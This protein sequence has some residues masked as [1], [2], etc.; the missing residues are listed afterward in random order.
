MLTAM[1]P[2][3]RAGFVQEYF[4]FFLQQWLLAP[5]LNLVRPPPPPPK[6][7]RIHGMWVKPWILERDGKRAYNT[8]MAGLYSTDMPSFRNYTR[9]NTE[10]FKI[11]KE[12]LTKRR[13]NC[14]ESLS[15]GLT[16]ATTLRYLATG[17]TYTSLQKWEGHHLQVCHPCLQGHHC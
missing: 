11:P 15:V 10:F 7:K 6:P 4:F 1:A 14:K 16:I 12:R 8:L 3:D 17:E 5:L 13:T 9:M 2:N